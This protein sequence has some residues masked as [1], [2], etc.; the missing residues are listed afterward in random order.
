MMICLTLEFASYKLSEL[1]RSQ[2]RGATIHENRNAG[3]EIEGGHTSPCVP[4]Q[5]QR[6]YEIMLEAWGTHIYRIWGDAVALYSMYATL[7]GIRLYET[8]WPARSSG[9]AFTRA[10]RT[11]TRRE[12]VTPPTG[13]LVVCSEAR[14]GL[15]RPFEH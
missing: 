9:C 2:T 13:E 7:T 15:G 8:H 4:E 6:N 12:G 14:Q 1:P 5:P 10:L 11:D 3:C